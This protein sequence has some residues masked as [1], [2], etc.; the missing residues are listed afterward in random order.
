MIRKLA[1]ALAAFLCACAATPPDKIQVYESVVSAPPVA[2]VVKRLWVESW[3]TVAWFP[4]YDSVEEATAAFKEHA[5]RAGGDGVINFGC[6][7]TRDRADAPLACN[8]TIVRFR[9]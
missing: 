7:R 6:Y 2:S 8:G 5:S 3:L 4:Y 9:P 1:P